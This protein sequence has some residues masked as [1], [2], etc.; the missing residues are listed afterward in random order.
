M[1]AFTYSLTCI[2][3]Q[4]PVCSAEAVFTYSMT[5]IDYVRAA[6]PH[7]WPDLMR[8]RTSCAARP[9]M[10][11]F[12]DAQAP[13]EVF[14]TGEIRQKRWAY[15]TQGCESVAQNLRSTPCDDG[16][17]SPM[18]FSNFRAL[19]V[20]PTVPAEPQIFQNVGVALKL[21]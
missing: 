21:V 20:H 2:D 10:T 4:V 16:K 1:K 12:G 7:G 5:C 9:D 11:K 15:L 8:G 17:I 3:Q 6:G 13:P 18:Y 19:G 14:K